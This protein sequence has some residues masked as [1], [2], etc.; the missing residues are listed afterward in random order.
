MTDLLRTELSSRTCP[1]SGRPRDLQFALDFGPV[2]RGAPAQRE[3]GRSTRFLISA[4]AALL[5]A[6]AICT[7]STRA[8]EGAIT[9][10]NASFAPAQAARAEALGKRVKCMC[11]GCDDAAGMCTHSGGNFAGPC[12]VAKAE[13]KEIDDRV[14]KGQ[15]DDQILQAFVQE[16]G[17]TVLIEPPKKGFDLLAWIMP[18]ALPI[19]AV[20]LVWGVVARWRERSSTLAPAD[21]PPVDAN[22]LARAQH[23]SGDADE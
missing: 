18:I 17:P 10:P 19:I 11:G 20:L 6:F 8:Q 14:A 23:E 2:L 4:A 5:L 3:L 1:R 22:L 9:A 7:A 13:L 21:G 16:Y 12:D 15:S